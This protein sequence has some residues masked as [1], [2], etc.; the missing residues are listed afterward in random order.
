M[1]IHTSTV[2]Y[3]YKVQTNTDLFGGHT[4]RRAFLDKALLH[5]HAHHDGISGVEDELRHDLQLA[6]EHRYV[7]EL[8]LLLFHQIL[9]VLTH[10]ETSAPNVTFQIHECC[11]V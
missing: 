1:P 7:P 2:Y 10:T 5:H 3:M 9:L 4:E 11:G 6:R 8:F